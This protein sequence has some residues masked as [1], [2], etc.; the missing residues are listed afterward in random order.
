MKQQ[1]I[2]NLLRILV[3]ILALGNLPLWAIGT[4]FLLG[5][6]SYAGSNSSEI[7]GMLIPYSL[8]TILFWGYFFYFFYTLVKNTLF[9]GTTLFWVC[10]LVYNI[11]AVLVFLGFIANS[12]FEPLFGFIAWPALSICLAIIILWLEQTY[13]EGV[14][15]KNFFYEK[16][17]E[18]LKSQERH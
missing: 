3:G 8:G 5:G 17:L 9:R 6:L 4:Y 16:H 12:G 10:H 2:F 11:L 14:Q 18:K 7:L 15:G 13:E 1:Q